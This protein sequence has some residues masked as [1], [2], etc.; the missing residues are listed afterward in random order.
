MNESVLGLLYLGVLLLVVKL[1]EDVF[2]RIRMPPLVGAIMGGI[3][4]GKSVLNF[5]Q[6]NTV[7]LFVELGVIM[8]LFLA[9]AEEFD[10][11]AIA[12]LRRNKR[13]LLAT[14][15]NWGFGTLL[16][17]F[18]FSF[19]ISISLPSLLLFCS[20]LSMSSVAPLARVLKDLGVTK[21]YFA[22]NIFAYA[23]LVEVAG[24]IGSAVF[25][26][27][28]IGGSFGVLKVINAV[29]P[30]T[31]FLIALYSVRKELPKVII[32]VERFIKS[33]EVVLAIIVSF[34]LILG[35]LGDSV[36]FNAGV[37]A[38]FLGYFFSRYLERRPH[39]LERLRGLT[40]GFFE[41]MF[42]G[43]LGLSVNLVS[44]RSAP[45]LAVVIVLT[46]IVV[47]IS[48]G[49]IG[50]AVLRSEKPFYQAVGSS[51]KGGVDGALLLSALLLGVISSKLYTMALIT[52]LILTTTFA[53]TLK[54]LK[55]ITKEK[56]ES[57]KDVHV[58]RSYIAWY[59]QDTPAGE[60]AKMLP[61]IIVNE[62]EKLK[63]VV[64]K[65]AQ[66]GILGAIVTNDVG[67]AVGTLVLKDVLSLS[68][69]EELQ[70]GQA[71]RKQVVSVDFAT[72]ASELLDLFHKTQIPIIAVLDEKGR[73]VS[74][75]SERELLIYLTKG[76]LNAET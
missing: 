26:Q 5:V 34:I 60:V 21:S 38:L 42:F 17:L 25:L 65:M 22:I 35:Y 46:V 48:L 53:P 51:L 28:A 14:F 3:I 45:L 13:L 16:M 11:E 2:E 27:L 72:P 8:M 56:R 39:I 29:F 54:G 67:E 40:Y 64:E 74:T 68:D 15:L 70:V 9:G 73:V 20:I 12:D 43:G 7:A 10:I 23:L 6:A 24:L 30:I 66:L 59:T 33:R 49:Y 47:K 55:K 63:P 75:V 18:V 61:H 71:M 32:A 69:R 76:S 37:V 57:I 52:I 62:K 1:F 44:V 19:F 4:L 58:L 50:G 36:G 31:L 41:P